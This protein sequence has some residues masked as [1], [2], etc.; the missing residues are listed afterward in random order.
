MAQVDLGRAWQGQGWGMAL[1]AYQVPYLS[2]TL[3]QGQGWG[4]PL[5]AYQVP[6]LS[7]TLYQLQGWGGPLE[8]VVADGPAHLPRVRIN[9]G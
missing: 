9:E 8:D 7:G 4:G 3:D 2:G 6:Y 1:I 5:I